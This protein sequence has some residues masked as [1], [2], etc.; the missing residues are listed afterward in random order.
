M[1]CLPAEE[2]SGET[3]FELEPFTVTARRG[4]VSG[5]A[6]LPT[7]RLQSGHMGA[8]L[9][10]PA[11]DALRQVPGFSLFRRTP[12]T[13]ANPT[14]QGASLRGIGPSGTSR[15]LVLLDGLPVND[16][17]GGWVYWSRLDMGDIEAIEVVRGG[18]SAAWGNTAL[19]GVI[20]FVSRPV[21][22]S[23]WEVAGTVGQRETRAVSLRAAEVMEGGSVRASA[24]YFST[25]GY[26]RVRSDQR[27]A[28]DVPTGTRHRL[29]QFAADHAIL[30]QVRLDVRGIY[31]LEDR[32]N[33]TPLSNNSTESARFHVSLSGILPSGDDWQASAYG[34]FS[35]YA[36][37]FT[38]VAPDRN[39]EQLVLDQY[40]VPSRALGA[41]LRRSGEYG[42]GRLTLGGDYRHVKGETRER[43]VFQGADRFAG[44]RISLLG[45]FA[46]YVSMAPAPWTWEVA[47][48]ADH[49]Q[50]TGGF[51]EQPNQPRQ[52]FAG[53]SRVLPSG[54][55]GF[56]LPLSETYFLR[57]AL[58]Q[59][60]RVPTINELY[61]PFQV[62][63]DQ[64]IANADLDPEELLGGE[65]GLDWFASGARLRTTFFINSVRDPIFNVTIGE[66]LQGGQL[67]QRQ[68]VERTEIRG[69]EF[70]LEQPLASDWYLILRYALSDARVRSAGTQPALVGKRLAQVP[71]HVVTTGLSWQPAE[72]TLS[73]DI[74][75]RWNGAQFEDDLNARR[76]HGFLIADLGF[77]WSVGPSTELNLRLENALNRRYP[78][79]IT[80]ANLV[81]EGTPRAWKMGLR[82]RF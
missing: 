46:E 17:F 45:A 71:R 36:N 23:A 50:Q 15:T 41:S 68:N 37:T 62:G 51:L 69:M 28:V 59:G 21:T 48:R 7:L 20:Q 9:A 81:T 26:I 75:A 57:A 13:A 32:G 11:D 16:A 47:L 24:R 34:E 14:T 74:N 42:S 65:V 31:F 54:R 63:A 53:R 2:A 70:D 25:D 76:L 33:G 56:T 30:P 38:S 6:V 18:G 44:G 73:A 29:L 79:G 22:E 80:G 61:R 39:S 5:P 8:A 77:S 4:S 55:I 40:S 1:P 52:F 12:S 35:D 67:R 72:S 78:D 60:F 49:W 64:T 3:P 82:H 27:G 10:V 58:Y 66:T 19:G 43:V